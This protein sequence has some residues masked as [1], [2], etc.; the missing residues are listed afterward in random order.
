MGLSG[1]RHTQQLE[2]WTQ[3]GGKTG[4]RVGFV[5]RHGFVDSRIAADCWA[6][7]LGGRRGWME[8]RTTGRRYAQS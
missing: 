7:G 8:Q 2:A 4:I 3:S 6:L 5:R 1:C